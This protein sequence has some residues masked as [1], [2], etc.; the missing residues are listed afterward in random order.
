MLSARW[1]LRRC[2]AS[3]IGVP[4]S[5]VTLSRSLRQPP[6][7]DLPSQSV[8]LAHWIWLNG[9]GGTVASMTTWTSVP[10]VRA[11]S[12]SARTH[13]DFAAVSD[14]KTTTALADKSRS[15]MTSA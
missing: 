14:H 3:A 13:C 1:P 12:A 7:S 6:Q 15:W 11:V 10:A 2:A 5:A 9:I 4:A 8:R